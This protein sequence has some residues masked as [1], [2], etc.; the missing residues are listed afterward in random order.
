MVVREAAAM[1]GIGLAIGLAA[2]WAAKRA[3]ASMLYGVT[4]ADLLTYAGAALVLLL[5]MLAASYAPARRASRVDPMVALR[6]E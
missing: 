1:A 3:I 4:G 5:A 6:L 2:A